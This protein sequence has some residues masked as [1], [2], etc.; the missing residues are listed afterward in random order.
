MYLLFVG[1]A[2]AQITMRLE[3]LIDTSYVAAA[4]VFPTPYRYMISAGRRACPTKSTEH[5]TVV[6]LPFV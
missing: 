6:S 3:A 4:A 5:N 1:T 2:K